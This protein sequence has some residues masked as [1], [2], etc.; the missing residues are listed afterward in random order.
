MRKVAAI[1]FATVMVLSTGLV[2][3]AAGAAGEPFCATSSGFETLSPPLPM[4]GDP[5]TVM[6]TITG[7]GTVSGC[8]GLGVTNGTYAFTLTLLSPQNCDSLGPSSHDGSGTLVTT[9]NT[10]ATSSIVYTNGA[11]VIFG[12]VAAGLFAGATFRTTS[13]GTPVEDCATMPLAHENTFTTSPIVIALPKSAAGSCTVTETCETAAAAAATVTTPGLTVVARGSPSAGPGKV[14][15]KIASASLPCP[16]VDTAVAP[17]AT[18]TD[19]GFVATDRL[20]VTALE[21]LT[22]TTSPAQ[23]CFTSTRPFKSQTSPKVAQLGP[24]LLLPCSQ[25]G[26]VAPCVLS[27]KQV[28]TDV[29][30]KFVVPGGD[31][32]FRIVVPRD[33]KGG[34]IWISRFPAA[35][36]GH[37]YVANLRSSGGVSPVRWSVASGKLPKG[38]KLDARS[39]T[40]TGTPTAKGTSTA[41]VQ[42]AD[43]ETPPQIA[44]ITVPITVH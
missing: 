27:S 9:W 1:V 43:S 41:V 15:L 12:T 42:A 24:A 36:K 31:P 23:V 2:V 26:N 38:C 5:T 40:I 11:G 21:P 19:T 34:Q 33:V 14:S 3:S 4:H 10:G 7:S 25:V 13:S 39:G 28:R 16:N 20:T 44:K 17:V 30:V 18:L 22:A 8:V 35:K 37:A 6:S 32:L 29:V